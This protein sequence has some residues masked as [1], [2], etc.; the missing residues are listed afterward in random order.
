M[1]KLHIRH[2]MPGSDILHIQWP[3]IVIMLNLNLNFRRLGYSTL[4]RAPYEVSRVGM[5]QASPLLVA[6]PMRIS[7]S[8]NPGVIVRSP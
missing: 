8:I 6:C 5:S 7:L 3:R 1:R 2:V 4:R